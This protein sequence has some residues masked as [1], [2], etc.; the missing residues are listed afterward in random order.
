MY[1]IYGH[2]ELDQNPEARNYILGHLGGVLDGNTLIGKTPLLR[3]G[4]TEPC[5]AIH[6]VE[7][8][9]G[10]LRGGYLLVPKIVCKR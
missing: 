9:G 10:D 7:C 6:G 5:F 4:S 2:R 3:E 1:Y 8:F